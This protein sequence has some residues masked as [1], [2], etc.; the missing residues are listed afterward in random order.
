[1][2]TPVLM[3][4]FLALF[5][6][7][8]FLPLFACA[9]E[10][11]GPTLDEQVDAIF[12][13]F[14]TRSGEV[15]VAKDGEIVYQHC[16]GYADVKKTVEV[17]PDHYYR[18]ASVSKL[19]TAA[20]VMRLVDDGRLDLDENIGTILGSDEPFFAASPRF[21]KVGITSRMLMSHTSCIWDAHFSTQRPLREALNVKT[22]Y[23]TSF[24]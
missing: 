8:I 9:E 6:S 23:D 10:A 16:Y 21:K 18:L 7:L 13:R 22:A 4:R 19:V 15:V 11:E 5:L 1:M 24:Y 14:A 3:K 20:A 12:R 2:R 17:T